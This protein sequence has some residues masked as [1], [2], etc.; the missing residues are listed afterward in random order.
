[1]PFVMNWQ[2]DLSGP[3]MRFSFRRIAVKNWLLS[4]APVSGFV[5]VVVVS[6]LSRGLTLASLSLRWG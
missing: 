2:R 1:M 3:W 4:T 5:A 6:L